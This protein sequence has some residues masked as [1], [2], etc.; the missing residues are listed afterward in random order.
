MKVLFK[1]ILILFLLLILN[2][3]GCYQKPTVTSTD[4]YRISYQFKLIKNDSVGN[5]WKKEITY[6]GYALL[7]N[8]QEIKT[9]G[10]ESI[11]LKITVTEKTPTPMSVA[12]SLLC[13]LKT[14][15]PLQPRSP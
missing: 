7:T 6:N 5:D 3:T 9:N 15:L 13:Y 10:R 11:V 8:G 14:A 1:N 4:T 2:L 12:R